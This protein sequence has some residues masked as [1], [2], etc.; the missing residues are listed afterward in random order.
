LDEIVPL[1]S[2]AEQVLRLLIKQLAAYDWSSLRA[3]VL[4]SVFEELIPPE[5][6]MLLGQ[7]YTPVPVADLIVAFTMNGTRPLVLDPGCSSGTFLMRAYDCL[8][9][10][11][12]LDHQQLLSII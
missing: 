9:A 12:H 2:I 8:A 7:F 4:G 5:E 3:D 1:P 10:R 6:Q 11:V